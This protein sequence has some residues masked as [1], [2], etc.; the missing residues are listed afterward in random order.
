[1]FEQ[2]WQIQWKFYARALSPKPNAIHDLCSI[3]TT[4]SSNCSNPQ[5]KQQRS[6][7]SR[8]T[9]FRRSTITLKPSKPNS[10]GLPVTGAGR[11]PVPRSA[12]KK[13]NDYPPGSALLSDE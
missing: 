5:M 9:C 4:A 12:Q 10:I 3:S 8:K 6:V 13:R 1:M 7:K 2:G 11:S